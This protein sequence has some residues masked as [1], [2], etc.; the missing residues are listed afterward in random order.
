MDAA[1]LIGKHGK[2]WINNCVKTMTYD[3]AT[4]FQSIQQ[5]QQKLEETQTLLREFRTSSKNIGFQ[6]VDETGVSGLYFFNIIF[7]NEATI[8]NVRDWKKAA[9][10]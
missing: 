2:A 4:T 5:G 7:Q 10:D 8:R 9:T 1:Q 3:P 6:D